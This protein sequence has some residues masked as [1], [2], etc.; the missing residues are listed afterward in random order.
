L[1]TIVIVKVFSLDK[2]EQFLNYLAQ[3]YFDETYYVQEYPDVK[4][5]DISPFEHYVQIGWKE[6]K[7]PNTYFDNKLYRN[8]YL[9]YDNKYELNPLAHYVRYKISFK[10]RVINSKEL[11][12]TTLLKNPN[13]YLALV[14]IFRDEAPFLKEWIEFYRLVGVEHFY[15]YNHL[16]K[17][18]YAEVLEPYIKEGIVE[19]YNVTK[20]PSNIQ[21]WNKI[22]TQAY[23]AVAKLSAD[24]TEWLMMVDTDEFLFPVQEHNLA[25]ALK[26]Y[27]DY[28]SVSVNWEIFGSSDV[29]T[30][31]RNKLLIETLLHKGSNDLHVKTIVKPRY[32]K[33]IENPHHAELK[34]GYA[35]VTENFEYF[36]GPFMPQESRNILRINH[37]WSRDLDF[38]HARKINRVHVIGKQLDS[39]ETNNKIQAI[40]GVDKY[41]SQIYD[42]SILK[43]IDELRVMVFN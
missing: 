34:P 30:I 12:K 24:Q 21:E 4:N 28:A 38:L 35:Q 8:L 2:K 16:S 20:E 5:L 14:A 41:N 22:Q 10:H 27:D 43:Y 13:Y 37:Y 3:Y 17:D 23:S 6:N 39:E 42:D 1:F 11:K 9:I 33:T 15:L 19:L 36:A 32:V 29:Q 31:P 26:N 25:N 40:I 7:N 18:E